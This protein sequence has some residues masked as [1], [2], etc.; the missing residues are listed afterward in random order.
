[1]APRSHSPCWLSSVTAGNPSRPI[2]SATI[3]YGSP[4]QPESTVSPA[5]SR[6]ASVNA[7]MAMTLFTG[8]DVGDRLRHQFGHYA[9][10]LMVG[11][12]NALGVEILADLV[13]DV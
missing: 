4:H 6:P 2:V 3:G 13:C 12:R 5:C 11:L 1:M 8:F 9:G 7:A 10:D